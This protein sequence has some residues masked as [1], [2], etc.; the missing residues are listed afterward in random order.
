MNDILRR[1]LAPLTS[2]A[3]QQIDEAATRVFKALLSARSLVDFDGPHGLEL[4]ATNTGRLE[5]PK[6]QGSGGV[7]WGLRIVQPLVEV[8]IPFSL[9]QMELDSVTRGCNDPDL[10]PLE[11]AARKLAMFEESAIYKGFADGRIKGIA[12]AAEAKPIELPSSPEAFPQAVGK[13]IEAL[14]GA[15]IG[16]PYT[17]V[18]GSKAYYP[19]MQAGKGGYP[20]N[21]LVRNLLGD[22]TIAWSPVLDGG[23]LLSTR[24]G[25]F[26]LTVGQDIAI[27][28][29][30][31]DR[32]KIEL[33]FTESF[34][35][36]VLEPAA[37][38]ELK[39]S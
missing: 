25:D 26:Q 37:A 8:R 27:G 6:K 39:A 18:L 28:Y 36:R 23:L 13:G 12:Q 33:Y 21:R 35:F 7:P 9:D 2:E 19:L 30:S 16:G 10:K 31:H 38:V 11:E 17:L 32:D 4:A 24:G 3:W 29:A 1:E 15:G 34:T 20:P 5:I 14:S 22:G